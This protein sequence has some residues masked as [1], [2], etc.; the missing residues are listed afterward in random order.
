MVQIWPRK[1][2]IDNIQGFFVVKRWSPV[3]VPVQTGQGTVVIDNTQGIFFS[4][5]V[6]SS[7]SHGSDR[8]GQGMVVLDNRQGFF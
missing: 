6:E 5:K 7:S 4:E 3:L 8:H 1:V 2:V